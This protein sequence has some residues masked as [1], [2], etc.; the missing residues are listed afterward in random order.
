MRSWENRSDTFVI[1]E[2][3]Y[4]HYLSR[5]NIEHPGRDEV[6]SNGEIDSAKVSHGLVN[7]ISDSHK[8]YYQKHMTHHLLDSVNRDWIEKVIN[9]F[10]I[11]NPKDM[12]ISYSK[13]HSEITSDLL[14]LE[15]QKEIFDYVRQLTGKTP[16]IIDSKD[17]LINPEYILSKFC[18]II[19]VNFSN[20]MLNWPKGTRD[21]DGVWGKYWYDG[22]INS[23][24]F[25]QYVSKNQEV[26]DKYKAIYEDSL[27]L[28]EDLHYLRIR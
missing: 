21:T 18:E 27:K 4:A 25:N 3:F 17:V 9:C 10:L 28:Y 20:E 26:P 16:P 14:G 8:I 5:N 22:V 1:D 12:I 19:G 15:Q 24:G 13:I 11:R 7:D 6:L 23:T 2:P